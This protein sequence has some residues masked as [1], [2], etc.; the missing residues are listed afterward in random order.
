MKNKKFLLLLIITIFIIGYS[1]KN[2]KIQ[3]VEASGEGSTIYQ[4]DNIK[5]KI[6]DNT[7][8]KEN[9][10]TSILNELQKINAFSPIE[11]LEI[12]ISKQY[13]Y[14]IHRIMD[15]REGSRFILSE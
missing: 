2:D 8:E 12:Q 5:I 7:D 3:L 14:I 6:S 9:I 11:N 15:K 13:K 4:N 10:Y 1:E